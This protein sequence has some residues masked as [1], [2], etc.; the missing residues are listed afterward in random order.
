M[1]GR[2]GGRAEFQRC[3]V[4]APVSMRWLLILVAV[5]TVGS[6]AGFLCAVPGRT[7]THVISFAQSIYQAKLP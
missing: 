4:A 5:A 3:R 6:S 1:L 2:T 7:R